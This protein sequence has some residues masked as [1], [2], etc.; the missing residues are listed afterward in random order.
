MPLHRRVVPALI[1]IAFV[2]APAMAEKFNLNMSGAQEVPGP[3]DPD[4]TATG[5][6]TIDKT[7]NTISWSFA[8]ANI[9]APT[10]MHIHTGAAGAAGGVLVNLG[11]ATSGGAGTL[12][13]STATTAANIN[14]ILANPPGFYVNIHNAAFPGGA[15]RGQLIPMPATVYPM[16]LLGQNEVPGPGDCDGSASGSLTVNPGTNTISWNYTYSNI[17]A[18]TAMHIHTGADGVAGPALVSLGVATTGGAGTLINSAANQTNATIDALLGNPAGHYVN[19][20]NAE[21]PGGAVRE[22]LVAPTP[23]TCPWDFDGSGEVDGDDLG[24][25]L[26]QWGPCPGCDADFN[27]DCSVDGDDLGSLLGGWGPCPI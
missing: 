14:T 8:F 19:I 21:F 11:V 25:L 12:I 17:A 1:A 23:S 16:T 24:T 15:V 2:V 20:H 4:G 6:L 22:Q 27:R 26:G 7:T 3:G 5:V 9:A 10:A 13:S 18:P